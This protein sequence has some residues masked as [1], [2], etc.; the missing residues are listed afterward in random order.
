MS[1]KAHFILQFC[2][3]VIWFLIVWADSAEPVSSQTLTC[4]Q[5]PHMW[6]NPLRK[7]WRP[8]FGTVIVKIDSR[9]DTQFSWASDAKDRI[10]AGQEKWNN[11]VCSGVTF[12]DFGSKDFTETELNSPAPERVV[13]WII[14]DPENG[15]NGGTISHADPIDDR[16]VAATVMIK[17][18][19]TQPSNG[20]YFTIWNHRLDI[21][22]T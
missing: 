10:K 1:R 12:T 2:L 22:L 19:F 13:H 11:A 9:F 6:R 5:P 3:V 15:A 21:H 7:F 14:K 8:N 4:P 17:P 16:I 20:V 18:E